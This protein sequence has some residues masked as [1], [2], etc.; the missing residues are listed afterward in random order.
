MKAN[1]VKDNTVHSSTL[2][3]LKTIGDISI[4][5][6]VG[7]CSKNCIHEQRPALKMSRSL[8]KPSISVMLKKVTPTVVCEN[9]SV[10]SMVQLQF[11]KVIYEE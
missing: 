1:T 10:S 5:R 2:T 7:Y 8:V 3:L 6:Y 9:Y 4:T 11:E